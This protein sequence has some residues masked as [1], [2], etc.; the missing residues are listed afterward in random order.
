MQGRSNAKVLR[1]G[2]LR[3]QKQACVAAVQRT[4]ALF[5]KLSPDLVAQTLRDA[6][7]ALGFV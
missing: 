2:N 3:N 1:S 6:V 4:R 7:R 5:G